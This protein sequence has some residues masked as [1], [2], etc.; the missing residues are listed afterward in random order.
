[1]STR[2]KQSSSWSTEE[3]FNL[4]IQ[5]VDELRTLDCLRSIELPVFG[6]ENLSCEQAWKAI[7]P[8]KGKLSSI[9]PLFRKFISDSEPIFLHR[10]LNEAYRFTTDNQ[11]RRKIKELKIEWKNCMKSGP[12]RMTVR[13]E[14]ITPERVID[15]WINAEYLHDDRE[16]Y[17]ELEYLGKHPADLPNLQFITSLPRLIEIILDTG[18]LVKLGLNKSLFNFPK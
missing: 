14:E 6:T 17:L 1:M 5:R 16:K 2:R 8:P 4:F 11:I 7:K 9:I 12:F 3:R 13:G 10:I 15:L 18:D